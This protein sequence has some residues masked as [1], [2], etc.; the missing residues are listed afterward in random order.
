MGTLRLVVA[1]DHDIVRRGLL[2]LLEEQPGWEVVGEAADGKEAVKKVL[3]TKPDVT[4]L[5]IRMPLVNGLEAAREITKSGSKTRILI[6]TM[7]ESDAMIRE[8]L[9]A[10]AR[11]YVLKSDAARD[12]VAAVQALRYNKTFFTSKVAEI[13]VNGF[14]KK[15]PDEN[16]S[17]ASR[18][19]ARQREI[20]KLLAEGK[21]SK[22][23]AAVLGIRIKT[24]ETHRANMMKRLN[25]HSLSALVRYA[26][27]NK[28]VAP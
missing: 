20:L 18:V 7:Y 6:L 4:I 16:E 1:D 8:V 28:I 2:N 24:L 12:L 9:D 11:G 15:R 5:D 10:G 25:C 23:A 26:L 21:T 13:V 27:R 22:E 19:T 17:P 3:E 14:S